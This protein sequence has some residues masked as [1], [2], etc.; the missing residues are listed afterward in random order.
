M[1]INRSANYKNEEKKLRKFHKEFETY[2]KII[3]M[4]K[5]SNDL[6]DELFKL[7]GFERLKHELS[8]YYS[9][10][11]NKN[12]GKIRLIVTFSNDIVNLEYISTKHYTD[13][14]RVRKYGKN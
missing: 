4:L 7:Y 1:K 8:D 3:N 10:N 12:G 13:F 14:K 11:L 2:N 5:R 6:N 9:F